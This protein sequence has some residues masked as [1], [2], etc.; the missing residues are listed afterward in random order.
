MMFLVSARIPEITET[1]LVEETWRLYSE[2]LHSCASRVFGK[3]KRRNQDWF[4]DS[5]K[6]IKKLVEE[7]RRSLISSAVSERR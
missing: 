7:Y 6:E 1:T 2:N 5:D 3:P 4:D